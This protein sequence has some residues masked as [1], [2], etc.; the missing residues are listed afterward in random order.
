VCVRNCFR[1]YRNVTAVHVVRSDSKYEVVSFWRDGRTPYSRRTLVT[2]SAYEN[3]GGDRKSARKVTKNMF[4]KAC[5]KWL[6]W[7]IVYGIVRL[8]SPF[9]GKTELW[10]S[11]QITKNKII[12][13]RSQNLFWPQRVMTEIFW[14]GR[15]R[16]SSL[17]RTLNISVVQRL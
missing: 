17:R 15:V 1:I 2:T 3:H 9:Y 8:V 10:F 12:D 16:V 7:P 4:R 6:G 11:R 14:T 5:G 13:N